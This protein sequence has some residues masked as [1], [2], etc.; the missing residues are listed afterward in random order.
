[1]ASSQ[2]RQSEAAFSQDATLSPL[3]RLRH[4]RQGY[5]RPVMLTL[6]TLSLLL[7]YIGFTRYARAKGEM[8]S[9]LDTLYLTLQLAVFESGAV[10][11]P[12]SWELEVARWLVPLVTVYTAVLAAAALFRVQLQMA[13]LWFVRN[14]VIVC[15]LGQKGQ[16]LV[17]S[18][19]MRGDEVVVIEQDA[20]NPQIELCRDHGTVVLVGDATEPA[21]LRRAAV[22]RARHVISVCGD[23]GVNVEVA[24]GT[25]RLSTKRRTGAVTCSIHLMNAQLRELL[26][27]QELDSEAFTPF[28]LELFNVF[29]RGARTML[30]VHPAWEVAAQA[31][32]PSP[33]LLVV[34]LGRMGESLVAHVARDWY[35]EQRGTG[36]TLRVSIVDR[37]VK[38]KLRS[39]AARYPQLP[40][41]CELAGHE[42]DVADV[43][44]QKGSF[45]VD[46]EG[47]CD[48]DLIY[49]CL[50]DAALGLQAAL[51]IRKRLGRDKPRIVVR[52]EEGNGLASLL[53]EDVATHAPFHNVYP[54]GLLERTCTPTLVL[55]GTHEVLAQ[56]VHEA[57]RQERRRQADQHEQ[58]QQD[59]AEEPL[60]QDEAMLPWELL[61]ETLKES[62]RRQ[63]DHIRDKL[64]AAGY[65]IEPLTDWEAIFHKFEREEVE[66]MARL[67]HE[68]FVE[69]RT[70]EGW[71]HGSKKDVKKKTSPDL[72]PWEELSDLAI[73]KNLHSVTEL[74]KVLARGEFQ[75]CR[76]EETQG[77][78]GVAAG[79]GSGLPAEEDT[80][81]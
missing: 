79:Q 46:R 78:R 65:G 56:A 71:V 5:Q 45:L 32:P 8:M 69:E 51:T 58:G 12:V 61:P 55:D 52:M 34:G 24:V 53:R 48:L 13:R 40:A 81:R 35:V 3:N 27:E 60:E 63:V 39:L 4:L 26:R 74:P 28:R 67:E 29:E 43:K 25:R 41:C 59:L 68:R 47:V 31:D 1:M 30:R 21:V 72:R 22:H 38:A 18:F 15:G 17:Q 75:V 66:L 37:E 54:F 50:R 6:L 57:Y 14:H 80:K 44:F 16:L 77:S 19:R 76:L 20:N 10:S 36:R 7:G 11:G 2:S 49:V 64:G 62:N 23:D 9:P 33:H 73:K 70:R 42:I